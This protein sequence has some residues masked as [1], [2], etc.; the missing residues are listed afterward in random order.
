MNS[1]SSSS[2]KIASVPALFLRLLRFFRLLNNKRFDA[3]KLFLKSLREISG[4]IFEKDDEAKGEK[5]KKCE[6]EQAAQ[7]SHGRNRNLDELCGQRP[8]CLFGAGAA[9][10]FEPGNQA[11]NLL[12]RCTYPLALE[13]QKSFELSQVQ[14]LRFDLGRRR[15]A[16]GFGVPHLS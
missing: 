3:R 9:S 2:S 5:D 15:A 11:A 12:A 10:S 4:P 14:A 7:Q 13:D 1:K 8:R 6:P 16:R